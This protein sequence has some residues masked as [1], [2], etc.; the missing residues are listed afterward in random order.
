MQIGYRGSAAAVA[1]SLCP[2]LRAFI[3]RGTGPDV[4]A[5]MLLITLDAG[6]R[7]CENQAIIL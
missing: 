3:N 7:P 1:D 2:P 5:K 6:K 4:S